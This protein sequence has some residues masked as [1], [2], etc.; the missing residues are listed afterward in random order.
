M[1]NKLKYIFVRNIYILDKLIILL[2]NAMLLKNKKKENSEKPEN[3]K[4]NFFTKI[5]NLNNLRIIVGSIFGLSTLG[6]ILI[7]ANLWS[8]SG[9]LALISYLL[10]IILMA[11]LFL[12]KNQ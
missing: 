5:P 1:V 12:A 8:I 6:I 2:E 10:L 3:V 11:N 7:F 9:L 4:N